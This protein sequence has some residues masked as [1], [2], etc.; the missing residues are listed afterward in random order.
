MSLTIPHARWISGVVSLGFSQHSDSV[1]ECEG[2]PEVF[3][4]K[5]SLQMMLFNGSPVATELPLESL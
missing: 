3:E 4:S 1:G 2:L 5:L